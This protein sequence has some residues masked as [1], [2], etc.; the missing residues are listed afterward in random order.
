MVVGR[1]L[2]S[3]SPCLCLVI[4]RFLRGEKPPGFILLPSSRV[5]RRCPGLSPPVHP[6]L[7]PS[8]GGEAARSALALQVGLHLPCDQQGFSAFRF[9]W[10]TPEQETT[11]RKTQPSVRCAAGVTGR[12]VCS[13]VTAVTP[14]EH[15]VPPHSSSGSHFCPESLTSGKS[16]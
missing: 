13:S 7:G 1:D 5:Q 9:R 11:R 16:L 8:C 12:T 3:V 10:R 2:A 6:A 14:G 15:G 4:R